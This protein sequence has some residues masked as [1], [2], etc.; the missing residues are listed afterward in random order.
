MSNLKIVVVIVQNVFK[1]VNCSESK[2]ASYPP[3]I[4][5]GVTSMPLQKKVLFFTI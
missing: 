3:T 2:S 5:I 4:W 1:K